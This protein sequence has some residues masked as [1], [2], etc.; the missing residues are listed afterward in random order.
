[1][2][3]CVAIT[4]RRG[5]VLASDSR[6]NAGV[7]QVSVYSKMHTLCADGERMVTLLSAGNLATTQAVVRDLRHDLKSGAKRNLKSVEKL[8]DAA[9][10]VGEISVAEQIKH[11]KEKGL[12]LQYFRPVLASVASS[13]P[14]GKVGASL[15][16][17]CLSATISASSTPVGSPIEAMVESVASWR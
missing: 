4:A 2:T 8:A 5:L 9:E 14:G 6:T 1:M 10:Y 11:E 17:C 13:H 15:S 7:D 12:S 3:Y 16:S